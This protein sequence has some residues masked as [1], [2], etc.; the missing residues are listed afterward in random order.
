MT[1][2][3][4]RQRVIAAWKVFA[5]RD[6]QA[7]AAVFTA[8]AEWLAP[9]GNATALAMNSTHQMVGSTRIARFIGVE[10][11]MLFVRDVDVAF[12][13]IY[14]EGDVVIVEE[15][16]RATLCHGGIYDNEYCFIFEMENGLI[17][18]V[19]EYM[20]TAR[21]HRMIFPDAATGAE[22]QTT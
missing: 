3:E 11:S 12:R 13:G 20:D 9:P 5:S 8:D 6:Q 17:R 21:G 2:E 18:R 10:F 4:N 22:I 1:P 16:M 15:R 19:R 14:A 7:I